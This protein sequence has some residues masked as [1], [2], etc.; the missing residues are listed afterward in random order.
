MSGLLTT[1]GLEI[2][3]S[4]DIELAFRIAESPWKQPQRGITEDLYVV[5]LSFTFGQ[6]NFAPGSLFRGQQI[7]ANTLSPDVDA[8]GLITGGMAGDQYILNEENMPIQLFARPQNVAEGGCCSFW[9]G[10]VLTFQQTLQVNLFLQR[11]YTGTGEIPL[12]ITFAIAAFRLGCQ[13]YGH[14]GRH[15]S[16]NGGGR[17]SVKQCAQGLAALGWNPKYL[18]PFLEQDYERRLDQGSPVR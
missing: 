11:S 2:I 4:R 3:M 5:D 6:P 7:V 12:N 14:W 16:S 8:Q 15:K 9:N 10:W 13:S 1:S 18:E 17:M